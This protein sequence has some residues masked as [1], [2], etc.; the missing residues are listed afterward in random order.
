[1]KQDKTINFLG[2]AEGR[3]ILS[4]EFDV[5]VADGFTG[6][7][8]L[9]SCEGTALMMFSLIKSGIESGGLRAKLGYL[10]LKPVLKKLKNSA[11]YNN[12]GGA[13]LLGLTKL[14][15]KAHGSCKADA[16]CA[17]ILQAVSAI[18]QKVLEKVELA[19]ISSNSD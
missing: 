2:N 19:L 13:I 7:I 12:R 9:K 17:T 6:N 11:D 4:G 3:D 16:F 10:F 8:A 14:V 15:I 1:M 5:I 18:E